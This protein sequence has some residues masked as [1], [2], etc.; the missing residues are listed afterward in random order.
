[1]AAEGQGGAGAQVCLRD[2]GLR[3][4]PA[5]VDVLH[6]DAASHLLLVLRRSGVLVYDAARPDQAPQVMP[7]CII[8]A[9]SSMDS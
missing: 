2:A 7:A 1:M 6:Y 4:D 3:F 8:C 5:H 9:L